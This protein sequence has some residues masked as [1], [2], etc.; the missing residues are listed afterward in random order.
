LLFLK[1]KKNKKKTID[2]FMFC[3]VI[4]RRRRRRRRNTMTK[5]K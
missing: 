4:R 5:K 3:K 2:V 1:I